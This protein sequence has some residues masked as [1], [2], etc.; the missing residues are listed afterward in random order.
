[1][2]RRSMYPIQAEQFQPLSFPGFEHIAT[3]PNANLPCPPAGKN[4]FTQ[5]K[6]QASTSLITQLQQPLAKILYGRRYP[7]YPAFA[8]EL[9]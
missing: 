1:M 9:G 7:N 5:S 2:V 8:T 3:S 6:L 4:S